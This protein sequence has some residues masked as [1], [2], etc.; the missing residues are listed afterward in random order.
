[1]QPITQPVVAKVEEEIPEAKEDPKADKVLEEVDNKKDDIL[2]KMLGDPEDDDEK[3]TENMF[4]L[5]D[6]IKY[7]RQNN[8]GLDDEARRA[9]AEVIMMKLAKMMDL[10][11]DYDDE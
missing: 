6:E 5:M 1:M 4:K 8:E 7:A 3:E 2:T 11:D 9:N 10:G